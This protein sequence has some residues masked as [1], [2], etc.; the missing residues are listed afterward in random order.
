[1]L[2]AINP[3]GTVATQGTEPQSG[4]TERKNMSYTYAW[5]YLPKA[6]VR[7]P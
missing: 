4:T 1:M 6:P 2:L 5:Y 3:P 7:L